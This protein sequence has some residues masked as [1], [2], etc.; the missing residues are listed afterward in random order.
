MLMQ[1]EV[2][3]TATIIGGAVFISFLREFDSRRE[4][5]V[6]T[7]VYPS[8][9][10][11]KL[12]EGLLNGVVVSALVAIVWR[13]FFAPIPPYAEV[14]ASGAERLKLPSEAVAAEAAATTAAD[15]EAAEALSDIYAS[16]VASAEEV[17]RLHFSV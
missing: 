13:A 9:D 12:W 15:I 16:D 7:G 14:P 4:T 2:Y 1:R 3:I 8:F 5:Y 11:R 10:W 17:R 6:R